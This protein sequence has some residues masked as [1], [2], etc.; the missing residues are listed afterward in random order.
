MRPL[1]VTP[2]SPAGRENAYADGATGSGQQ[3]TTG[4]ATS[5]HGVIG[6]DLRIETGHVQTESSHAVSGSCQKTATAPGASGHEK[7]AKRTM[8]GVNALDLLT[9]NGKRSESENYGDVHES[10]SYVSWPSY[11]SL[12][13]DPKIENH[14]RITRGGKTTKSPSNS[15]VVERAVKIGE[16][17]KSEAREKGVYSERAAPTSPA[18]EGEGEAGA[19]PFAPD[20]QT[21]GTSTPLARPRSSGRG[22]SP[23]RQTPGAP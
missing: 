1:A 20:V 4:H 21:R 15:H 12:L 6:I 10:Y 16:T 9:A 23:P 3:T 8:T 13:L 11:P 19:R 14:G 7:R 17:T 18:P 22:G 2:I 5:G